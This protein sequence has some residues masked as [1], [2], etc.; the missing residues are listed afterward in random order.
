MKIK[1]LLLAVALVA[2]ILVGCGNNKG[3]TPTPTPTPTPS[4]DGNTTDNTTVGKDTEVDKNIQDT[5]AVTSASIVNKEDAFAKAIS[6]DGTWIIA[7]LN[8]LTF[9]KDLVLEG[10]FKNSKGETQ[11]K[12]ALY[13]QD[14]NRNITNRF[15]L[16]APKLTIR[17]PKASIQHGTFKGDLYVE[18][19]DFELIDTKVDGNIYFV[20]DKAKTGYKMDTDSSVTG[21]QEVL[22]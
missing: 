1:V 17:S 6:K 5:D 7:T 12:I 18:T 21:K 9:D 4:T 14:E 10:D 2:I 16:T 11:R 3:K 19:E 13:T 22:K 15:I 20:S 8:D